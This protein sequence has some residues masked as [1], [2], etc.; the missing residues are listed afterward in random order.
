M[1]EEMDA[2][3]V[4]MREVARRVRLLDIE[5]AA[6]IAGFTIVGHAATRKEGDLTVVTDVDVRRIDSK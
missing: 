4:R 2:T 5:G 6:Q 3:V 1:N